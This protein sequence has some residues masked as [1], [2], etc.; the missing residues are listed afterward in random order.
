MEQALAW[1]E[2]QS[3]SPSQDWTCLCQSS[4]RQA[5]GMP[6][7]APS[8]KQAWDAVG[9]KYKHPVTKYDDKGWWASIPAGGIVY[10]LAGTYGHAWLSAGD[11]AG[12]TVDYVR[13][14]HIDLADIRLKGWSSYYKG[15]AGWI[16]GCQ[17]YADN[18]HRFEGLR[19]DLWDGKIPPMENVMAANDDRTLANAAVWRLS[20]R[21]ADLGYGSRNWTPIKYEQTYPVR[22]MEAY[23]DVHAPG[24]EDKSQYGPKAHDRIFVKGK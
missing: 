17:W 8:A 10:S 3:K 11:M 15:V 18:K 20:C 2:K 1:M 13:R 6:A 24:M 16:D 22:A 12:W 4:V 14:G 23:N 7:W 21:L 19:M 9:S 5:Y